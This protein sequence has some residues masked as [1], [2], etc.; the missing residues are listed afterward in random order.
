LVVVVVVGVSCWIGCREGC[1][2]QVVPGQIVLKGESRASEEDTNNPETVHV[3]VE[4]NGKENERP[5]QGNTRLEPG[6]TR[7]TERTFF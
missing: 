1:V 6:S 2:R 5:P 7:E 3:N 4:V